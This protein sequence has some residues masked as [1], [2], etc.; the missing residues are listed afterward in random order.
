[1][2]LSAFQNGPIKMGSF[3]FRCYMFSV[4]FFPLN[5]TNSNLF[6]KI[7]LLVMGQDVR[8]QQWPKQITVFV[9]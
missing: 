3:I 4:L 5:D 1:M 8:V 9:V 7:N 6:Y 2:K